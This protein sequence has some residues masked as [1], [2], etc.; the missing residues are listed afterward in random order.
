MIRVTRRKFPLH[1]QSLAI[2]CLK[3]NAKNENMS[4]HGALK[5]GRMKCV[6]TEADIGTYHAIAE[7]S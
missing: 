1:G 4:S 2:H 6:K 5:V 7:I 3:T